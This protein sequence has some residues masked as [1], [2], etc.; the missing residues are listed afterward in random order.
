MKRSVRFLTYISISK[1]TQFRVALYSALCHV[2]ADTTE[3]CDSLE[4]Q[5]GAATYYEMDYEVVLALGLTELK[6]Y[7]SWVENV[8]SRIN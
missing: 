2:E 1:Q 8:S 5:A 6:A 3:I 4:P 7:I